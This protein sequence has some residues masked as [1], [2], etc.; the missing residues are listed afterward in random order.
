L[1]VGG[2]DEDGPWPV[3]ARTGSLGPRSPSSAPLLASKSVNALELDDDASTGA[4]GAVAPGSMVDRKICP[5][6]VPSVTNA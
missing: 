1:T 5:P 3:D 6:T 4:L 2:G